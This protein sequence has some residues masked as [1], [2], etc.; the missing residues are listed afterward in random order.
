M[1][2]RSPYAHRLRKA[3]TREAPEQC[4]QRIG[5]TEAYLTLCQTAFDFF[6]ERNAETASTWRLGQWSRYEWDMEAAMLKF[7]DEE[8][9]RVVAAI[10]F[11]GTYARVPKTW[12]WSWANPSIEAAVT[13][14]MG[15]AREYGSMHDLVPLYAEHWHAP[16]AHALEMT[17]VTAYLL[18]A[19]GA[20]R[21]PGDMPGTTIYMVLMDVHW[22]D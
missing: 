2:K 7:F 11:A 17:A 20:Y 18:G 15:K 13:G 6:L 22:V 9:P 5:D 12:M 10:E 8:G 4:H 16:E 3:F 14:R 19:R 1:P 21:V